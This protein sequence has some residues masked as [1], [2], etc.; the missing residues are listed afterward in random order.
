MEIVMYKDE[1]ILHPNKVLSKIE[2]RL[3]I[4]NVHVLNHL[5]V[6]HE[7][8]THFQDKSGHQSYLTPTN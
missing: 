3:I 1:G 8:L 6:Q 5:S 7:N 2:N 4:H